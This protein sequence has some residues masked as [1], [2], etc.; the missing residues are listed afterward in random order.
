MEFIMSYFTVNIAPPSNFPQHKKRMIKEIKEKDNF[1]QSSLIRERELSTA[2]WSITVQ[3]TWYC[4]TGRDREMAGDL[5]PYSGLKKPYQAA[6]NAD[7]DAMKSFYD[8]HPERVVCPLTID[9]LTALHIAGYNSEGTELLQHLLDL[10]PSSEISLAISKKSDHNN[11]VFHE[12]ASTNNVASA[13]LLISKFSGN[14]K[15]DL[16]KIL[17]DRNQIG[18][19]PLFRAAALGQIQMAKF[20]AKLVGDTSPHF[21][22]HDSM[23]ILHT[24]VLGQHFGLSLSLSLSLSLMQSLLRK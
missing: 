21:H 23:S 3:K 10:L 7:W 18:E 15:P 14:N 13:K 1:S 24:A 22:R 12:V 5:S 17:E 4:N 19:T 9:G 16:K 6:L 8:K 2:S 20:L 11:N